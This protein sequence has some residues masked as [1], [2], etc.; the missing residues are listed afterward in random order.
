MKFLAYSFTLIFLFVSN[1]A[2]CQEKENLKISVYLYEYGDDFKKIDKENTIELQK[3]I[4]ERLKDKY[5]VIPVPLMNVI[6]EGDNMEDFITRMSS[7][8]KNTR[9]YIDTQELQL[10]PDVIL[11]GYVYKLRD[12][13]VI[14]LHHTYSKNNKINIYPNLLRQYDGTTTL[15][16]MEWYI[17]SIFR[18]KHRPSISSIFL[19]N[20]TRNS[21]S[22]ITVGAYADNFNC[23]EIYYTYLTRKN[24]KIIISNEEDIEKVMLFSSNKIKDGTDGIFT[25]S[26]RYIAVEATIVD[27]EMKSDKKYSM[28]KIEDNYEVGFTYVNGGYDLKFEYNKSLFSTNDEILFIYFKYNKHK[29]SLGK[30]INDNSNNHTYYGNE[31]KLKDFNIFHLRY[32]LALLNSKLLNDDSLGLYY[33]IG[34]FV[35][36]STIKITYKDASSTVKDNA[37]ILNSGLSLNFKIVP[38]G[39]LKK[40][41]LGF[42]FNQTIGAVPIYFPSRIKNIKFKSKFSVN[43]SIG[44]RL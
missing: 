1:Y 21:F 29:L 40:L 32:D 39:E 10:E 3:I 20:A 30:S 5:N 8:I 33:T 2:Y 41:T 34:P 19:K 7:D 16:A 27:N 36:Y 23:D 44:Y 28:L 18:L 25:G 11:V 26:N 14:N 43:M 17:E 31:Y 37:F 35:N 9:N 4:F 6:P 13:T 22:N 12:N 15:Q 24:A 38:K 42:G